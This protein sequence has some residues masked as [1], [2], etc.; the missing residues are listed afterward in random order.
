M[1]IFNLTHLDLDGYMSNAVLRATFNK[2]TVDY[3]VYNYKKDTI[4][5]KLS[6]IN[7]DYYDAILITDC[8]LEKKDITFLNQYKSKIGFIDHHK[9]SVENEHLMNFD[10]YIDDSKCGAKLCE[11]KFLSNKSKLYEMIKYTNIYDM[12]INDNEKEY[13]KADMLNS[14]FSLV[15]KDIFILN[16]LKSKSLKDFMIRYKNVLNIIKKEYDYILSDDFSQIMK[17]ED[18]YIVYKLNFKNKNPIICPNLNRIKNEKGR[19]KFNIFIYDY[20]NIKNFFKL[21]IRMEDKLIKKNENIDLNK[22]I[23]RFTNKG[24]GH[25]YAVGGIVEKNKFKKM[26]NYINN[27]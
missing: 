24:G 9:D 4:R 7:M 3:D 5:D 22:I 27:L 18:N 16:A 13:K 23:K 12:Y 19:K 17:S 26:L 10:T 11:E 6:K 2:S 8:N 14:I 21:S 15:D 1:K 20:G 25:N